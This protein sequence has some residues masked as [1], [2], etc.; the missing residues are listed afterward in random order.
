MKKIARILELIEEKTAV[1]LFI[2]GSIIC[3]YGVFMRYVLNSPVTWATEIFEMLMAA[4]IFIGFGMALKDERHIVVDLV[5]DKMSPAIKKVFN[6]IS[7]LLGSGFSIYLTI[8]GISMVNVAYSQ[9][10]VSIDVGIPIWS[11]YLIMPIG[12]GL[13]SLYFVI[14][15]VK[16]IRTPVH[17]EMYDKADS[18]KNAI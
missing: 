3:I 10:R 1:F 4:A 11:T 5:Y 2:L 6:I 8:M 12:M 18:I 17:E 13:L 15:T 7:N 16:A 9:G 14:R